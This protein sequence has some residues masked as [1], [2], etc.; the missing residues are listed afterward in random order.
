MLYVE[1]CHGG[2]FLHPAYLLLAVGCSSKDID[3]AMCISDGFSRGLM[4]SGAAACT[5]LL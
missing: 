5:R 2:L 3:M 4:V 1:G